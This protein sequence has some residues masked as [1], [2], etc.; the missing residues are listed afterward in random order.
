MGAK[1]YEYLS[2]L[3]ESALDCNIESVIFIQ[4]VDEPPTMRTND[5]LVH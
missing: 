5:Y 3:G 2:E 4:N 1:L